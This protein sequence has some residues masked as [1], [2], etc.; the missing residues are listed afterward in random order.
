MKKVFVCV[1]AVCSIFLHSCSISNV[2]VSSNDN[3]SDYDYVVLTNEKTG[4]ENIDHILMMVE[5]EILATRLIETS[6]S[7]AKDLVCQ[8]KK[9]L[10][11]VI[12]ITSHKWGGGDTYIMVNFYDYTTNKSVMKIKSSEID[13]PISKNQ[14]DAINT[15]RKELMKNFK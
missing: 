3:L 2:V 12:N 14:D 11:P 6:P 1:I 4:D 15:I 7:T 9:V 5:K 13:I 8:G 10:S